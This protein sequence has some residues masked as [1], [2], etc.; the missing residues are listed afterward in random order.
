MLK[1]KL[2]LA[3][4]LKNYTFSPNGNTA[5]PMKLNQWNAILI[6]EDN[7]YMNIEK[8]LHW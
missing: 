5:M 8:I 7:L 6:F 3:I 2:F 4:L 1:T